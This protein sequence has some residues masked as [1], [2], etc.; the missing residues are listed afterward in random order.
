MGWSP[1]RLSSRG[2]GCRRT[3]RGSSSSYRPQSCPKSRRS[4]QRRSRPGC[5]RRGRGRRTGCTSRSGPGR[6][7]RCR[8]R[9]STGYASYT[10]CRRACRGRP[11]PRARRGQGPRWRRRRDRAGP[12][13]ASGPGRSPHETIKPFGIH[14]HA[15][16]AEA[17]EGTRPRPAE[18]PAQAGGARSV[19]WAGATPKE[20]PSGMLSEAPPSSAR[21]V[22]EPRTRCHESVT[23][24]GTSAPMT[25]GAGSHPFPAAGRRGRR[26]LLAP[27]QRRASWRGWGAE[28][29]A[30]AGLFSATK[31][32]VRTTPPQAKRATGH[33]R[34]P[35]ANRRHA[36][37]KRAGPLAPAGL[38][39][40]RP[41]RVATAG[42]APQEACSAAAPG[43]PRRVRG[44]P[45]GSP[46]PR[47]SGG[48]PRRRVDVRR[49]LARDPY[50]QTPAWQV[51]PFVP[52][53][54]PSAT[55][56]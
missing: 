22:T 28:R 43:R 17:P 18:I 54:V 39:P 37:G 19:R 55:G 42:P 15:L 40:R 41:R 9:S 7:R 56:L 48:R 21:V 34:R 5:T 26:P 4:R 16:H 31:A 38:R 3:F 24:A 6:C 46:P 25:H 53:S 44:R 50:L 23:T 2:P 12:G 51:S 45:R 30:P 10:P 20:R 49:C 29:V 32:I 27:A 11:T 14:D 35:S 36:V 52:Q 1:T 33:R 47:R 8:S 13:A